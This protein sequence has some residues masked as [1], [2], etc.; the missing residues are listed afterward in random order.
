VPQN[1]VVRAW[2]C[3]AGH[4]CTSV[5]PWLQQSAA[6][7]RRAGHPKPRRRHCSTSKTTP[8]VAAVAEHNP[9]LQCARFGPQQQFDTPPH[10]AHTVDTSYC[11][12]RCCRVSAEK[13]CNPPEKR[14]PVVRTGKHGFS[15][16]PVDAGIVLRGRG[17]RNPSNTHSRGKSAPVVFRAPVSEISSERI[18]DN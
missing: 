14:C 12:R 4:A 3:A 10:A 1:E 16:D 13:M 8:H 9:L 11:D 18:R 17:E 2:P 7:T 6:G 5:N 15:I